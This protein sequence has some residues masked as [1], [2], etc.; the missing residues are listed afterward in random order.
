MPDSSARFAGPAGSTTLRRF[1]VI[2]LGVLLT[3]RLIVL[4]SDLVQSRHN[5]N[6]V[7]PDV[8]HFFQTYVPVM[9]L[10]SV[11]VVALT[12]S[13]ALQFRARADRAILWLVLVAG[14]GFATASFFGP[15]EWVLSIPS[16]RG[17]GQLDDPAGYG[18]LLIAEILLDGLLAIA[19]LRF[20]RRGG[21][22]TTSSFASHD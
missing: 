9:R 13:L 1:T 21:R 14:M 18:R 8:P 15:T 22:A 17:S 7:L 11:L 4:C 19:V 3:I 16:S 10:T 2:G 20:E 5:S 12:I 6:I